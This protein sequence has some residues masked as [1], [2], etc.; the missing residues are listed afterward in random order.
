MLEV[1]RAVAEA[2]QEHK[3][4]MLGAPSLQV[5]VGSS[6]SG[7]DAGRP[8][9]LATSAFEVQRHGLITRKDA[10]LIM[11][12]LLRTSKANQAAMH[13]CITNARNL[14]QEHAVIEV[15]IKELQDRAGRDF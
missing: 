1:K 14:Q 3:R 9:G 10:Q 12:S 2:L 8:I 6:S 5:G 4:P 15:A 7:F 13:Q 11:D